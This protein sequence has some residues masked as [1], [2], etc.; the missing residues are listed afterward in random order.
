MAKDFV[1]ASEL[2][3]L[4]STWGSHLFHSCYNTKCCLKLEV[5]IKGKK[6]AIFL[7]R[8]IK[9]NPAIFSARGFC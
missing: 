2:N 4:A 8:T 3:Q 5:Q 7:L 6:E 9:I 1:T